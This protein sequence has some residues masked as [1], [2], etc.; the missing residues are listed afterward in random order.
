MPR[1][2]EVPY[3]FYETFRKLKIRSRQVMLAAPEMDSQP[4]KYM[5][6]VLKSPD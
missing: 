6:K 3:A 1:L 4:H 2:L 5:L